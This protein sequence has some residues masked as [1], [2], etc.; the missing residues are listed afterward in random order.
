MAL[1]VDWVLSRFKVLA[2][3][4]SYTRWDRAEIV[5]AINESYLRIVTLKPSANP[6]RRTVTLDEGPIQSID[7]VAKY[8]AA[9]SL[10]RVVRNMGATYKQ[11]IRSI[12]LDKLEHDLPD[13]Y[14]DTTTENIE[15][16]SQDDSSPREYI[17]YPPA[18]ADTS[19]EVIVALDPGEHTDGASVGDEDI[20]L[21]D[22]YAPMMLDYVMYR[23]YAKDDDQAYYHQK[24]IAHL[25]AF[26]AA[27][28]V[29]A[30]MDQGKQQNG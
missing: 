20:K 29:Q 4:D 5:D 25:Q 11:A 27:L 6:S 21:P 22:E 30:Q 14:S 28:N 8:G 23:A 9:L 17:V 24:S 2:Q 19:V 26:L 15:R 7:D 3:D 18:V 10:I 1:T 13:W 16:W 12:P